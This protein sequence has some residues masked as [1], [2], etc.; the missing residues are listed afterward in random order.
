MPVPHLDSPCICYREE[1]LDDCKCIISMVDNETTVTNDKTSDVHRFAYDYSFWSF[2]KKG[3]HK[4]S[5]FQNT[6]IRI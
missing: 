6:N 3:E 4:L 5:V 2:D 1:D